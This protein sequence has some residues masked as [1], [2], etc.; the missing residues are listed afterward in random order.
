MTLLAEEE[1]VVCFV[2][3]LL[4][5]MNYAWANAFV[6]SLKTRGKRTSLRI[7][8]LASANC[9]VYPRIFWL[10]RSDTGVHIMMVN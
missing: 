2:N 3:L 1:E 4:T 10:S 6:V 7:M 9:V 8:T 5:S